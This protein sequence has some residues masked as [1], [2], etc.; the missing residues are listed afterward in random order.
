MENNEEKQNFI[1]TDSYRTKQNIWD[2]Y[3]GFLEHYNNYIMYNAG[4]IMDPEI[5]LGLI[6]Y[7]TYF[8]EEIELFIPNFF[9]RTK[10]KEN[11]EIEQIKQ[12][13]NKTARS[14]KEEDYKII[15]KFF[16]KFMVESGIKNIVKE[17][18]GPIDE[19]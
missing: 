9:K 13:M 3:D 7:T 14:R 16:N 5:E 18:H 8:Y 17:K 11:P 12:I 6:K 4:G 1:F 15:R 10:S 19:R 2:A